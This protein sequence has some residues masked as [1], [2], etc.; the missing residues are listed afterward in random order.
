[1]KTLDRYTKWLQGQRT[2]L[3]AFAVFALGLMEL[4]SP[5]LLSDAFGLSQQGRASATVAI[6]MAIFI[7]RQI[8]TTSPGKKL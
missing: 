6:G 7:L 3:L 8:T 2:R 1:M 5:N 4:F